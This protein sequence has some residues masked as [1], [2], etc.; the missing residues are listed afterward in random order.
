MITTHT[1]KKE[2][3]QLLLDKKAHN[4]SKNTVL[5]SV[6]ITTPLGPMLAIADE[7]VLHLLEFIDRRNLE[8]E[9]EHLVKRTQSSVH[10]GYTKPLYL[11]EE[12]LQQYFQ[13]T[14]HEFKTPFFYHGS[15][16]A[17]H[18]WHELRKIPYGRTRSYTDI[19]HAI[20]KPKA[21]RAVARANSSNQLALVIPCHRVINA[22]GKLGG[23]SGG[24]THKEWL[25]THEKNNIS[26]QR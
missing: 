12:E 24:L 18:V 4:V 15:P 16:F 9:I 25:L 13:G 23:Y 21:F 8:Q 19:A 20:G 2:Y 6:W 26:T 17:H 5:K 1:H 3:Y 14:L 11:I 7:K 10:C 22:N